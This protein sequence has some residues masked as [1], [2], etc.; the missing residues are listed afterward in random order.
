MNFARFDKYSR[1]L[2]G[3][4]LLIA[5][6]TYWRFRD[7]ELSSVYAYVAQQGVVHSALSQNFSSARS[8]VW[9]FFGLIN[10]FAMP[11]SIT[12]LRIIG[13]VIMI[14]NFV[15]LSQMLNYILGQRFWGFLSVF[16]VALSPFAVVAAVSG[17]SAAIAVT[18]S[19][20]F[21]MAIYRNEYIFA[22]I[23]SGVAFAANLPGLVMFLIVVLD[24]L[25][26]LED[27]KKIISRLLSAAA[28][29][30][31]VVVLVY[32]YSMY[33]GITRLYSIP[34]GDSDLR[35]AI[36]GVIPLIIANLLN[37]A[38]IIYLVLR[39]RYDVYKTH[40][41][42]LMLWITSCALCFAQPSTLNLLV[43]LTVSSILS[44]FF[45]QGFASLW[46]FK[47]I[48]ADTFIFLFV[49]LFLSSALYSNN[50]YLNDV[51]VA[52]C[53][54]K[55]EAV[56]EV[57]AAILPIHGEM[58]LVSNFAPAELSVKLGRTVYAVQGDLLPVEN[59][60][61]LTSQTIYVAKRLSK[62]DTLSNGCAALFGTTYT[63]N[64]KDYFVQVIKCGGG[65]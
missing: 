24:L 42:T 16:M 65:K 34:L 21:L 58:Q 50:K 13:L 6:L 33:S 51:V 54:Q 57:I 38:G 19:I 2:I 27:K 9:D 61:N 60:D 64:R 1:Y 8:L 45:L 5:L 53:F 31:G 18:I 59:F 63:E 25:Q 3:A 52:D 10:K 11:H 32:L 37:I 14:L 49:F 23:L 29:F 17:G 20:L 41:H 7:I 39:K 40:F 26:N 62:V 30:F 4:A 35:W 47:P 43:A 22:G 12:L 36:V 55:G 46:N 56:D 28:G 44:M 48:S 15:L